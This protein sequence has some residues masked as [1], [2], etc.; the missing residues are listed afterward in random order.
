MTKHQNTGSGYNLET[1]KFYKILNEV[2]VYR[3]LASIDDSGVNTG[4]LVQ[5]MQY[6]DLDVLHEAV[7]LATAGHGL[8][9][10]SNRGK[11]DLHQLIHACKTQQ[12]HTMALC[13]TLSCFF[14]HV[15]LLNNHMF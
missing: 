6:A 5:Q 4:F 9:S 2:L 15:L 13:C 10:G 3:L 1:F 8:P 14:F 12:T 7:A 11:G